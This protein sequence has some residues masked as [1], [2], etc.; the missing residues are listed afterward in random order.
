MLKHIFITK[1]IKTLTSLALLQQISET[2]L[3]AQLN[4]RNI[5]NI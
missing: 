1:V 4:T 2:R 3:V 5:H